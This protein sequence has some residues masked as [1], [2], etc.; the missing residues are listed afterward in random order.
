MHRLLCTFSLIAGLLCA[1]VGHAAEVKTAFGSF[2]AP[3]GVTAVNREEK[4]DKT[5]RPT[6]M[7]VYS[8]TDDPK[9]VFIIVWSYAE[10]DPAKPYDPLDGAVKIG[11]PFDKSLTRDAAKPALVGGVEGGRYEGK[12]PN[13]LR[14]VSYVAVKDGYRLIVLLKGPATSPYKELTDAFA[15]GVEGFSWALPAP[16]PAPAPASAPPQ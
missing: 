4:P 15:K 2:N 1:P 7:A 6:G 11:N 10:P 8:R 16:A 14:A 13:G 9:G 3:D 5:G 12:L